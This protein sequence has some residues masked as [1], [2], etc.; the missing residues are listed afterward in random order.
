[1][2][3]VV[4]GLVMSGVLRVVLRWVCLEGGKRWC[5]DIVLSLGMRIAISQSIGEVVL[6]LRF[7]LMRLRFGRI[8]IPE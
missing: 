3:M 4:R 7:R 1:M 5:L 2:M 8:R 6:I